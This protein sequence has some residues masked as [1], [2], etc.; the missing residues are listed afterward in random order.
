MKLLV[1]FI[2]V[3]LVSA[4]VFLAAKPTEAATN[5]SIGN[6]TLGTKSGSQIGRDPLTTYPTLTYCITYTTDNQAM[7][8]G[9]EVI[10]STGTRPPFGSAFSSFF[11]FVPDP[12]WNSGSTLGPQTKC[13]STTLENNK[14]YTIRAWLSSGSYATRGTWALPPS[15]AP[16]AASYAYTPN[17]STT[18]DPPNTT[19]RNPSSDTDEISEE[20][21]T[22]FPLRI[23]TNGEYSCLNKDQNCGTVQSITGS[24]PSIQCQK[25][26][27]VTSPAK[28]PSTNPSCT[29][30]ITSRRGGKATFRLTSNLGKAKKVRFDVQRQ[31]TWFVMG[32]ATFTR[33]GAVIFTT[34]TP[35]INDPGTYIIRV[36]NNSRVMCEGVLNIR[37]RLS[38]RGPVLPAKL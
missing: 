5:V 35:V 20:C 22:E 37:M 6:V 17:I 4:P 23:E 12:Y 34:R 2:V 32:S 36:V 9:F 30:I 31:G 24:Q 26:T 33:K 14:G 19:A 38:L 10:D 8:Y 21:P 25:T 1:R 27:E 29:A 13:N 18:S 3:L 28:L 7:D 15:S 16:T 11:I